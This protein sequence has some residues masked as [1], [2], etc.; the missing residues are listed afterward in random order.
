MASKFEVLLSAKLS[1]SSV[2]DIKKQLKEISDSTPLTIKTD[3]KSITD[4][5]QKIK[6]V[7]NS[8]DDA[9]SKTQGLGD[10]ISKFSQ[11]QIVGDVIH[12]V[13]D[14][15]QDMVQQVFDLDESLV[16]FNKVTD[17]TPQQLREIT[18][19]AYEL[20]S[21]VSR[22][23]KEAIDAAAN[24]SK[25]GYKE[26][27]MEL[28]KTALLYQNIA[29]EQVSTAT[30]TDLIVSQMK[31]FNIEAEDSIQ[32][33]DQINE[34]S[35][36]FSVSSADLATAIPKVSATLAQAGNS[37][38]E[39]IALITAGAE[40]MTGQS[41]RVARGL[42]SITLNLQGMN[43]EG[44]QDLHLVAAM[45]SDF[46]KLG[47]TLYNSDGQLKSTFEILSALA[48]K[49]PELDQNTKNYYASLIGGR[50]LPQRIV[51]CV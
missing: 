15:I 26:N 40:V 4:F 32:I 7:G 41:S 25:A 48:D 39:T 11:W 1:N 44:E 9:K 12:G 45:E 3:T 5:S 8:A 23:G 47:I 10:I 31:A 22:T 20:G 2:E 19:Q 46:N 42:R 30:A 36:N 13:K 17:V 43:D 6:D 34:V 21:Q 28:A 35:N 37:M 49:F 33:I 27:N 18:D 14:G 29:D 16:E 24:F 50:V 38:S 51:I